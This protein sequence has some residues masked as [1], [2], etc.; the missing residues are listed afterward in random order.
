MHGPGNTC[1]EGIPGLEEYTAWLDVAG[2]YLAGEY[3]AG[4]NMAGLYM[5]GLYK[6]YVYMVRGTKEELGKHERPNQLLRG[7]PDP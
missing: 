7:L 4:I 1:P 6:A 5:E 3:L 2:V